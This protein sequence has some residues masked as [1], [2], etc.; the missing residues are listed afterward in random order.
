[1]KTSPSTA[2]ILVATD[3][4]DDAHQIVRQLQGV[5]DNVRT[6]TVAALAVADFEEC[7][8]DVL[9][10]GFDTLEKSQ[11]YYLGLY[12]LGSDAMQA[13]HCTVILCSKDEVRA[14]FDLCRKDFFYDY[15]LYWPQSYD[16]SRLAMSVWNAAR[17]MMAARDKLP[18]RSELI[19]H[20]KHLAE[21][22]RVVADPV[23]VS[24]RDLREGME[25]ALAGTRPLVEAV[26]KLR[27]VVMVI[28]D[29]EFAR[30]LVLQ[31]LDPQRWEVVSAVDGSAA[32]RHLQSVQPDVILM[33]IRLPG[34]DGVALTR[35]L[36]ASPLLMHIPIIMMT[37]DA[38]RETLL[39]SMEAGAAA[40]VV[41]PVT[42]AAL[43]AKLQRVPGLS[44]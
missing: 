39:S 11:G 29:D 7:R 9:V 20:A 32:L 33:D 26:R 38:R 1:M 30:G 8:P 19:D 41:K 25:P 23:H 4:A 3:N 12:R 15:V 24:A 18:G 36:K 17:Q 40:F 43:E 44:R 6:S 16:G 5:F 37:G 2:R 35:H 10:L 14:A 27:Q 22:E 34:M 28:D 21:L 31:A 13:P 42:R